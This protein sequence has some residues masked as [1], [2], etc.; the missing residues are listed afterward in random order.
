MS[1]SR[2]Y[3]VYSSDKLHE[4]VQLNHKKD[5]NQRVK[6]KSLNENQKQSK[7]KVSQPKQKRWW[8][9]SESKLY[10][11]L[12]PRRSPIKYKNKSNE[13][14]SKYHHLNKTSDKMIWLVFG[15]KNK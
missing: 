4:F 7:M 3:Q 1:L 8:F 9:W 10:G 13:S 2:K 6:R 14:K 5:I 15:G 12:V 11:N